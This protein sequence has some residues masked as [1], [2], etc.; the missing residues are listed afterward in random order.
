MK[1]FRSIAVVVTVSLLMVSALAQDKS[2]GG[3]KG[4]VREKGP[5]PASSWCERETFE[6]A[7]GFDDSQ[8]RVLYPGLVPGIM[9]DFRKTD[10]CRIS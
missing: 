3:I 8:R 4:K 1:V 6:V 2:T 5:P 7:R 10:E 9:V